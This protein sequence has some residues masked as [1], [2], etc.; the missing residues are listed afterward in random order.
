V[1]GY[2]KF[3]R[4]QLLTHKHIAHMGVGV[5]GGNHSTVHAGEEDGLGLNDKVYQ[6]L[7]HID[8][9]QC[10]NILGIWQPQVMT[11]LAN[12][13]SVVGSRLPNREIRK[14]WKH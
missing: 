10:V 12:S 9:G 6:K 1:L 13:Q 7:E 2:N 8:I 4:L 5:P 11:Y 14:H 3:P